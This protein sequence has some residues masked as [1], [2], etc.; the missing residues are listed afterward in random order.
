MN[1]KGCSLDFALV[2]SRPGVALHWY[3]GSS[4]YSGLF[5]QVSKVARRRP[6]EPQELRQHNRKITDAVYFFLLPLP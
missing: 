5:M 2:H 6:L 1:T 3:E 4:S